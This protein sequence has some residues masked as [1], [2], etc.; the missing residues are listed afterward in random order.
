MKTYLFVVFVF[1][2]SILKAQVTKTV[3]DVRQVWVSYN[4]QTR[5]TEKLGVWA[6]FHLRTKDDFAEDFSTGIARL[7]LMYYLNDAAK[8]TI[9][10]AY[11]HHFPMEGHQDISRPENRPWQ[12][13]QWH[14]K[15]ERTRLMQWIRLEER[16]RRKIANDSTL[17][18]GH[19]FNFKV[20]YN[21]FYEIP[22]T[23]KGTGAG[24]LSAVLNDELHI[25]F[26]KEVVYNYFDQNRAFVGIKINTNAHDNVQIGY[27]NVFQQLASGNR[28][29]N[30][31]VIRLSYFQNLD[32]RHSKNEPGKF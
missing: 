2:T 17:A 24:A 7:G 3:T 20:R 29:R 25:S 1:S 12:Q 23:Q 15:Y 32:W 4:N 26:G 6:D 8:V 31:H 5:L 9:G 30:A 19:N 13:L 27:S 10:Y 11:V 21:I 16:F 22:L 14:T 28:F 18:E